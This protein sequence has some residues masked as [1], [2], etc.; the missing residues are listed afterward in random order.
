MVFIRIKAPRIQVE[1]I[2][3]NLETRKR[4]HINLINLISAYVTKWKL[5]SFFNCMKWTPLGPIISF[6]SEA[7]LN[8]VFIDSLGPMP[9]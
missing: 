5:R 6:N 2:H 9:Q 1:L 4:K 3:I 7:L 8:T